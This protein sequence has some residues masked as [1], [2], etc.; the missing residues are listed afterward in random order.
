MKGT[1]GV[2]EADMSLAMSGEMAQ[3]AK[4]NLSRGPSLKQVPHGYIFEMGFPGLFQATD[5]D[6]NES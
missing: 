4:P 1:W 3:P 6:R 5:T 2:E